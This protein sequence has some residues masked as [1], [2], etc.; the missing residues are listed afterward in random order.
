[1]AAGSAPPRVTTHRFFLPPASFS[2]GQVQFSQEASHQIVRVL[3]LRPHDEV[4]ALDGTGLEYVVRLEELQPIVIG[5]ISEGRANQAEPQTHVILH[6]GMLKAAKLELVLQKGTE[7]GVSRFVP[8]LTERS[9]A[10]EPGAARQ[11]R[12]DTIVREAAEQC[13]RGRVP[14]VGTP[15]PLSDAL[16]QATGQKIV[17]WEDERGTGLGDLPLDA[18]APVDLFVGPEGGFSPTEVALA[19]DA[20]ATPVSLGRRILRAETAAMV[21]AALVLAGVADL[22]GDLQARP[23]P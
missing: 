19:R 3:R 5:D 23:E 4:I 6:L 18:G 7:I 12:F 11:R 2:A 15:L 8:M 17:L 21:A 10:A 9:V 20:G 14:E 16:T 22:G 13:G 1:V